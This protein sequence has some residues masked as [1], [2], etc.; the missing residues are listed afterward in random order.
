MLESVKHLGR[1]SKVRRGV[2]LRA[3]FGGSS[4]CQGSSI[5]MEELTIEIIAWMRANMI[6]EVSIELTWQVTLKVTKG[7][8]TK[9]WTK[10]SATIA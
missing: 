3:Y 1:V 5:Y 9:T 6:V 10:M 8:T 4:K 7:V 2:G